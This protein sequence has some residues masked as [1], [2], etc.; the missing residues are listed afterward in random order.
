MKIRIGKILG[1]IVIINGISIQKVNYHPLLM[2]ELV[3]LFQNQKKKMQ[4]D[5]LFIDGNHSY[6]YHKGDFQNYS[7]FVRSGG[8][9]AFHDIFGQY[10][11]F[12][13]ELLNNEPENC[14]EFVDTFTDTNDDRHFEP[15]KDGVGVRGPGIGIYKKK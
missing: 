6:E 9:I 15:N 2:E 4:V 8:I 5:F 12:W 11:H 7:K 10:R 1:I 13:Q 3:S 14:I